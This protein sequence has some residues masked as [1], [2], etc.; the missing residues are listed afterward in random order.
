MEAI[1]E[2]YPDKFYKSDIKG[3]FTLNYNITEFTEVD[4]DGNNKIKYRC[5]QVV[6]KSKYLEDVVETL[7]NEG[8]DSNEIDA[9]ISDL[10]L[11]LKPISIPTNYSNILKVHK[12][13][14]NSEQEWV[15][16][17]SLYE[18][19][20]RIVAIA[21]PFETGIIPNKEG[22]HVDVMTTEVIQEWKDYTITGE[23]SWA[24]HFGMGEVVK[25]EDFE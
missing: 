13:K 12:L 14:F 3:K 10:S 21:I 1:F 7:Q 16:F 22:Y 9:I 6:P 4:V 25:E 19:D 18:G 11:Q 5:N 20:N 24:H 17:K 23:H 8:L 2:I 15:E